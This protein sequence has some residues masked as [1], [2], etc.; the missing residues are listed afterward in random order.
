MKLYFLCC[1]AVSLTDKSITH[2]T[3]AW[4]DLKGIAVEI[5]FS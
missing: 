5:V 4:S 1:K 3:D 2:E